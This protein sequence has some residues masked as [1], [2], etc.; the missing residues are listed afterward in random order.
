[1][2]FSGLA[3]LIFLIAFIGI[4]AA[5]ARHPGRWI[6]GLGIGVAVVAFAVIGMFFV[7]RLHYARNVS[8]QGTVST[9]AV[10]QI[11]QTVLSAPGYQLASESDN[12]EISAQVSIDSNGVSVRDDGQSVVIG[13]GS[14]TA[15]NAHQSIRVSDDGVV[16]EQSTAPRT[17]APSAVRPGAK[18]AP[19]A[20]TAVPAPVSAS[21]EWID[22]GQADF[23]ADVYPSERS[24]AVAGARQVAK[25]WDRVLPAGQEP[26]QVLVSGDSELEPGV[27]A[28]VIQTLR[29]KL[30]DS[31]VEIDKSSQ[32][33]AAQHYDLL[34]DPYYGRN[35]GNAATSSAP[36][37]LEAD[38]TV[39]LTVTG[40]FSYARGGR[41]VSP[42]VKKDGNITLTLI[43]PAGKRPHTHTTTFVN[44]PWVE[45][46]VDRAAQRPGE[47]MLVA[48]SKRLCPTQSEA[49]QQAIAEAARNIIPLVRTRLERLEAENSN[50][51]SSGLTILRQTRSDPDLFEGLC[52]QMNRGTGVLDQFTQRLRR[53][54][55]DVWQH[56]VLVDASDQRITA[57][58][59][60][61]LPQ[62]IQERSAVR[63]WRA[64][65]M[66]TAVAFV[67]LITLI[68]V[69]YAF[70]NAATRGY[71]TWMLRGTMVL[72]V[73]AGAVL[74]LL[75]A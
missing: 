1:M 33:K 26:T 39:R 25:S 12:T 71:Y 24:A 52:A 55:G 22:A 56:A 75:I 2:A 48:R 70:L 72:L 44:E 35:Q 54:Y 3:I 30:G 50:E 68:A 53:P 60:T 31:R 58:A 40:D 37:R 61:F 45:G 13:N 34:A 32:E 14:V 51:P 15:G 47:E 23:E 64:S 8:V 49:E 19:S 28:A 63:Q 9:S 4:I 6:L 27:V 11:P 20:P 17:R 43:D 18:L 59:Q 74:L 73:L 41:G 10:H 36:A 21:D 66:R 5:K 7:T 57:Y 16:L 46:G 42:S 29:A 69:V 67:L 38:A 62:I 65:W